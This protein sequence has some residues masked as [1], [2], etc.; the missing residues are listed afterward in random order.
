MAPERIRSYFF[1]NQKS[2]SKSFTLGKKER[3]K[4]RKLIDQ[5]FNQGKSFSVFPYRIFYQHQPS[6]ENIQ[7]GFGVSSRNFK[8]AVDRNKIKRLTREAYRIQKKS[9]IDEKIKNNHFYALFFVYVGKEL[10]DFELVS[11]KMNQIL[12]KLVELIHENHSSVT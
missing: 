10:P 5:L 9:W 7:A 6:L 12:E 1:L 2:I 11:R 8:K 3:L 4:S